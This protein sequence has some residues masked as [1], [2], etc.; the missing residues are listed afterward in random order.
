MSFSPVL[1]GTGYAGW[2]FLKRTLTSQQ[3]SFAKD[4]QVKRDEDYFRANIGKVKT[5]DQLVGDRRLLKV[6]LG[7][8]G[9]DADIDSKAFIKKVLTDGTLTTDA[10]AN[11]MADKQYLAFS[12]A[13][14]FGDFKTPRTALSTFPDEILTAYASRSFETAVGEQDGDMRL[15]LNAL[16]ELPALAAR[17]NSDDTKWY[18]IIGNT[19]MRTVVQAALGLPSSTANLDIDQQ[20]AMFK[21]RAQSVLGSSAASQFTDTSKVETLIRRYL[22]KTQADQVAASTTG[23]AVNM[24]SQ[25]VDL[26]RSWRF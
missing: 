16:R 21:S 20:V 23:A 2:S 4:A 5:A 9:L 17:K 6:A 11:K 19:P 12:A 18:S 13:F 24:L 15:A 1:I 22:V 3:A 26:M 10:L 8:F 7:A 14:G 25:T